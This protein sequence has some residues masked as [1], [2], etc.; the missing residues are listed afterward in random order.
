MFNL[1]IP[2]VVTLI[3][4]VIPDAGKAAEFKAEL[5]RLEKQGE[6]KQL[7]AEL[8]VSLGQ[9]ELNKEEA[10]NPSLFASGW[11]PAV[12][13]VCVFGLT[14][15]FF[16]QPLLAWASTIFTIAVP[17]VLDLGSLLTLLGGMLGLGGLRTF[18]KAKHIE[19]K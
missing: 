13:W 6:L 7:E 1:L 4:K 16:L 9:I 8:Q 15:S 14:Y 17:P 10:K 5:Y 19:R 2:A 11:R 3:D 12:G 18:E